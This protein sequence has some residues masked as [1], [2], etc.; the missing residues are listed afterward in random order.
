MDAIMFG[1]MSVTRCFTLLVMAQ[2]SIV[3]LLTWAKLCDFVVSIALPTQM[4]TCED[5]Q[6][7]DR[8]EPSE[9]PY[10]K[11]LYSQPQLAVLSFS[12]AL[13]L[14]RTFCPPFVWWSENCTKL[15]QKQIVI[16]RLKMK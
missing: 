1:A 11:L 13:V 2:S 6:C 15:N 4:C 3:S 12:L 14:P 7:S 9:P 10:S 8:E 16:F 5:S